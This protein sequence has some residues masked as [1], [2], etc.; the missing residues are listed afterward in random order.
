MMQPGQVGTALKVA[1]YVA[2]GKKALPGGDFAVLSTISLKEWEKLMG[3]QGH[4]R[5]VS[6][7]H[8][9]WSQIRGGRWK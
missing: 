8:L 2:L 4:A 7:H 3:F 5:C 6:P 9:P 1:P